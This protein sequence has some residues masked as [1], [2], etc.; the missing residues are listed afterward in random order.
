SGP[1]ERAAWIVLPRSTLAPGPGV[2]EITM[3]RPIVSLY[4][5]EKST[6][7]PD[8]FAICWASAL[9][10]EER[11]GAVVN[12]PSV[13]YQPARAAEADSMTTSKKASQPLRRFRARRSRSAANRSG[14]S[15]CGDRATAGG[16]ASITVR[17]PAEG[18]E[19]TRPLAVG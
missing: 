5:S 12:R 18:G 4:A 16:G 9:L 8:F 11:S 2:V 7:R 13:R 10:S 14:D 6:V 17:D 15:S 1:W 19:V 3:P